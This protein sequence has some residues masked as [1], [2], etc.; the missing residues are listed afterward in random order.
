MPA[1]PAP[2]MSARG[3]DDC[4]ATPPSIQHFGM[5]CKIPG[6]GRVYFSLGASLAIRLASEPPDRPESAQNLLEGPE[7][8]SPIRHGGFLE[9]CPRTEMHPLGT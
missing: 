2:M 8:A 6:L 1:M 5:I 3:I 7:N 4:S 9:I